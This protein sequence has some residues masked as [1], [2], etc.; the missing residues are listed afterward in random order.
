MKLQDIKNILIIGA[1]T[2]GHSIAQVYAQ[3]GFEVEL[4]DINENVLN[5]SLDLIKAN[6]F[7]LSEFDRVDPNE[8]DKIIHRIHTS[9]DLKRSA[10]DV[11]LALEV[12]KEVPELKKKI[13]MQ[14][15]EY[16]REDTILASNTSSLN[17]Y[18]IVKAIKIPERF[19]T[20]HWFAP[21]HI[22]PLVEIVPSRKTSTE[23]IDC[24]IKLHEELGKTPILMKKFAANYIINKIQNA[25]SGAIYELM[26]RNLATAEQIDLAVK[27]SLGIRLPIVGVVQLHDFTGLDLVED[28]TKARGG[29]VPLISEKVMKGELG[30][31][32][33]K[34]H[35]NYGTLSEAEIIRKRDILYLKQLDFLEKTT[36]FKPI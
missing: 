32:T 26:M 31:K 5:H 29:S 25:I 34:G 9:T 1:G 20:H 16:C 11:D 27:N 19:I 2:M 12:V 7:T 21:P 30:V 14:L 36:A 3:G 28:I 17:I 35:Y 22:I 15:S 33:G 24:S 10:K 8:I 4:V 6:L 13:F 18:K 23:V